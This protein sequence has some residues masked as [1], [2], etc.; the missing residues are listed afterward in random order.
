MQVLRDM[1]CSKCSSVNEHEQVTR[2][3][4]N[5]VLMIIKC[6]ECGHEYIQSTLTQW[7]D[8]ESPPL[9]FR[10]SDWDFGIINLY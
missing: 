2:E 3:E 5:S 6:K 7:S 9:H 8:P 10:V 4:G 1:V